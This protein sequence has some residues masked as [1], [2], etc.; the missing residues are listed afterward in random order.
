MGKPRLNDVVSSTHWA[1]AETGAARKAYE[2][3]PSQREDAAGPAVDTHPSAPNFASNIGEIRACFESWPA[4]Q[5]WRIL[6]VTDLSA[7]HLSLLLP[8]GRV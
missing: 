4:T 8:A 1:G 6:N 3:G 7:T 5:P 2:F